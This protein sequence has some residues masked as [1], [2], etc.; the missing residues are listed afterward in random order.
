MQELKDGLEESGHSTYIAQHG[1][2][3][4]SPPSEEFIAI[5]TGVEHTLHV[6]LHL[7]G[8]PP[9]PNAIFSWASCPEHVA[10]PRLSRLSRFPP[11][12]SYDTL[13]VVGTWSFARVASWGATHFWVDGGAYFKQSDRDKDYEEIESRMGQ[14]IRFLPFRSHLG[15]GSSTS[16]TLID[17]SRDG[18]AEIIA[19]Y[20]L[21][22]G[23][24]FVDVYL[25]R[26]ASED[27]RPRPFPSLA[28]RV[29]VLK[30]VRNTLRSEPPR[31]SVADESAAEPQYPER[32]RSGDERVVFL[33]G[34][35][36]VRPRAALAL[37]A[38][39]LAC[40]ELGLEQFPHDLTGERASSPM[41]TAAARLA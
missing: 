23:L 20:V 5:S 37:A 2:L 10:S 16:T 39:Q 36:S 35:E 14:A 34:R 38:N 26:R 8:C 12:Y 29:G 32:Q 41:K 22:A 18:L 17:P 11:T 3:G 31:T 21:L 1:G 40:E 6:K 13:A 28:R 30:R 19:A 15:G 25:A 24:C 27:A 33:R 7:F 9:E 4:V